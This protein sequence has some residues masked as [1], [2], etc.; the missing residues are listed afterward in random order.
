MKRNVYGL[1]T[2]S[3]TYQCCSKSLDRHTSEIRSISRHR[4]IELHTKKPTNQ[5]EKRE[6]KKKPN[7]CKSTDTNNVQTVF[8][9]TSNMLV[10][11]TVGTSY[12]L[13]YSKV[14]VKKPL[15]KKTLSHSWT[16]WYILERLYCIHIYKAALDGWW[17]CRS[18]KKIERV[19]KFTNFDLIKKFLI[20]YRTKQDSWV[21]GP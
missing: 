8:F 13:S 14:S 5:T 3:T 6:G 1:S 15:S 21:A 2:V 19:Q 16:N 4:T 10:P 20:F 11:S 7:V 17:F 18:K 9:Y 12:L